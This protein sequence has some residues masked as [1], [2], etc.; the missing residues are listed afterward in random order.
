MGNYY[1]D[2]AIGTINIQMNGLKR[3]M[4]WKIDG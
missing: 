2:H 3:L 1:Q 4:N